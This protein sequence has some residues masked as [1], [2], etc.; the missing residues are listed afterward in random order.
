MRAPAP[1]AVIVR[2]GD[3]AVG[4]SSDVAMV[5]HGPDMASLAGDDDAAARR[6][7]RKKG[8]SHDVARASN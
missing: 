6:S 7:A 4:A 3:G 8:R 1:A 2:T 5:D